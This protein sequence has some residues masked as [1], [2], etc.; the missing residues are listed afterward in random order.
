MKTRAPRA[1]GFTLVELLVAVGL[2]ALVLTIAFVV[3]ARSRETSNR[4]KCAKQ[5]RAIGQAILLYTNDNRGQYPRSIYAGGPIVTPTWGTGATA[6]D[7]FGA[8]GP[9]P[10]DVSAVMFLLARTMDISLE[11]FVCPS[12]DQRPLQVD[13]GIQSRSNWDG[14]REVAAHLS[15][16]YANPYADDG[17]TARYRLAS[18]SVQPEFALAADRNPG[19]A[20][21]LTV[22]PTSPSRALRRAN[23]RNHDGRGQNVLFGDGHVDFQQTPFC[24]FKND[25]IYARRAGPTGSASATIV[26][27][28]FDL[29][30]SVLLP[31]EE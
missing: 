8:G 29:D 24:G 1:S 12:S 28:P 17:A 21:V 2:I 4:V 10:N 20:D 5:L 6:S 11:I 23:S 13:S 30:D 19:S 31:C 16:S 9:A 15:Y 14:A 18:A 22:T 26:A 3:M 7:P 25:N 27:S